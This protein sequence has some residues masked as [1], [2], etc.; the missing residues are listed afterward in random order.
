M[1]IK[2]LAQTVIFICCLI[3]IP[4]LG[5]PYYAY[6]QTS[7]KE[8]EIIE[9][10]LTVMVGVFSG[11]A[12]LAAAYIASRL[13][14]DWREQHR[15]NFYEKFYYDFRERAFNLNE[16]Y[17]P[18]KKIL[19]SVIDRPMDSQL[20]KEYETLK[21]SFLSEAN[22]IIK[23]LDDL[24]Y[25]MKKDN[26]KSF[27]LFSTYRKGILDVIAFFEV[28]DLFGDDYRIQTNLIEN[29]IKNRKVEIGILNLNL[30]F[31]LDFLD[32]ILRKIK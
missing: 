11:S 18:I 19:L 22:Y 30:L 23:I 24:L 13:F 15:A 14:N 10:S 31:S 4:V 25:I 6:S 12:T 16:S 28:N 7:L 20:L 17:Q 3:M 5:F 1:K 2:D 27:D 32:V 8:Y 29:N 26:D 9:K 21:G